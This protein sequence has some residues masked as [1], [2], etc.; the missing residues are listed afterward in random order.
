MRGE[1]DNSQG[2]GVPDLP[3][4]GYAV[5]PWQ[6]SLW[7]LL[8]LVTV[9]A[10]GIGML[11]WCS[12]LDPTEQMLFG[13]P[14]IAIVSLISSVRGDLAAVLPGATFGLVIGGICGMPF[15]LQPMV[16]IWACSVGAAIGGGVAAC[17]NGYVGRGLIVTLVGTLSLVGGLWFVAAFFNVF[18]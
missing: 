7:S 17:E 2:G 11:H 1:S 16:M 12:D 15:L 6:F 8:A 9:V 3:A 18:M 4:V 5:R 14:A 13:A 10:V